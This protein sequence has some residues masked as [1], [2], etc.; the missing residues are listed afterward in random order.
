MKQPDRTMESVPRVAGFLAKG[1]PRLG[2]T[3][4][5]ANSGSSGG[6]AHFHDA[7]IAIVGWEG[8]RIEK[9]EDKSYQ[10][11]FDILYSVQFVFFAFG[12][13]HL[14]GLRSDHQPRIAVIWRLHI[15]RNGII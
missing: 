13:L 4:A 12:F 7:V 10:P 11:E 6:R 3:Q 1:Q 8:E 14:L 2:A 15:T 9:K 5:G